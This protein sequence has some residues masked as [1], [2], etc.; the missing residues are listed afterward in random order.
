MRKKNVL[1][2]T[3]T[4]ADFGKLKPLIRCVERSEDFEAFLFVTGMH[5]LAQ[6]GL[7]HCEVEKEGFSNVHHHFFQSNGDIHRYTML[8]LI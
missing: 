3:G 6:Y 5:M 7:T 4:R 2:L 1:F 8:Q